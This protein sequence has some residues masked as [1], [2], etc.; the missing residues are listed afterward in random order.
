MLKNATSL[1]IVA[2][3]TA[4]NEPSKF[5]HWRRA[6]VAAQIETQKQ[7]SLER[8]VLIR[9]RNTGLAE[10]SGPSRSELCPPRL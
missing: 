9:H 2:L 3:G 10:F 6:S 1:A 4:E 8:G 5:A 7:W